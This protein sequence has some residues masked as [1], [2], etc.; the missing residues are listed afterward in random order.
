VPLHAVANKRVDFAYDL[1]GQLDTI[2]RFSSLDTSAPV[3]VSDFTWDYVGRLETL[4]HFDGTDHDPWTGTLLAGYG[5]AWNQRHELTAL[6]FLPGN[7]GYTSPFNYST[8]DVA[9]TYDP[10]GQ[11]VGADYTTQTDETYAYDDNGNRET[12]TNS[13]GANQDYDTGSDNR[14]SDDDTYT[15]TYDNEGNR[16]RRTHKTS[17]D[18]T[19]YLWDHRN[20]LVEVKEYDGRNTATTTDDTLIEQVWNYYDAANQW[21]RRVVDTDGATG[22]A[23]VK[24]TVFIH[25]NGQIVLQ[26]DKTGSGNLETTNLSHRYLWADIVDE[27]LAD[28]QVDWSDSDADG[29]VLWALT[30]QAGSVRDV[31]DNN[32]TVRLHR[33]F[34]AYGNV[35]DTTY[36]NASGVE[37]QEAGV[38]A[39]EIIVRWTGKVFDIYTGLQNNLHRWYDPIVATFLS[40]DPIKD[41][42]NW[43]IYAG[44]APTMFV[45]PSGL[46]PNRRDAVPI[47]EIISRIELLEKHLPKLSPI[48]IL[49][50][51]Q[52]YT[53]WS[54]ISQFQGAADL[55]LINK[56]KPPN[57]WP[58]HY[59]Y[60]E[61]NGWVD[62]GHFLTTARLTARNPG[63]VDLVRRSAEWYEEW[64][65][66]IGKQN[67]N[68]AGMG[69]SAHTLEDPVS[70]ELGI[71]FGQNLKKDTPLSKQ[72]REFFRALNP[73][74][75]REAWNYSFLPRD[76]G[77]WEQCWKNYPDRAMEKARIVL[78]RQHPFWKKSPPDSP[79]VRER[80]AADE[81]WGP[82]LR[83][84]PAKNEALGR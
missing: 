57:Q 41:G 17:Y 69:S 7:A 62:M 43:R 28:E 37:V 19:V 8:E 81:I 26:F 20:R 60:T 25:E 15:Y 64:S 58:W 12:V 53:C 35:T 80:A 16:T 51:Y 40:E 11:L 18:S 79:K 82:L 47:E 45:D 3:A 75:P 1:A 66:Q 27:L 33:E 38:G 29:E 4:A 78:D 56:E 32:G 70:N 42:T 14:L 13:G 83:R 77:E 2:Q 67:P 84:Q 31:V 36:F 74:N 76:E 6:D 63:R 30:D 49:E 59:V 5:Y 71:Q 22:Q 9:Y 68:L 24:Q 46:I 23:L 44:N 52:T 21:I 54:F 10:R 48:E 50:L 72:M 65:N 61:D 55:G 73:K 34:D 39:V